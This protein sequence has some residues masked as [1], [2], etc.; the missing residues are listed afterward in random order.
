MI[1]LDNISS[2]G[3]GTYRMTLRNSTHSE[4]L[5]YAINKGVN[6]IDTSSNY[7]SGYS[8]QLI[9]E[10]LQSIDREDVFIITK[11]G[12]I[13]TDDLTNFKSILDND[14]TIKVEDDFYYSFH[15]S[16]L[17]KQ[18]EASLKRLNTSYIDGFLIH[19]P[20][21]YFEK[22]E[23][24]IDSIYQQL[25]ESLL[26]LEGLVHKGM[27][28]YYGISSNT[29]PTGGIDLKRLIDKSTLPHFRLVQFPYNLVENQAS[30][31]VNGTSLISFCKENGIITFA[32][33][34]LNTT[35]EGNVLRLANYNEELSKVDFSKEEGLFNQFLQAI[36][37][38]L[39]KF[40]ETSKPEDFTPIRFFI[41]N[42]K[43]IANPEAV[44]QAVQGHLLPFIQQLQ[45]SDNT[46][47]KLIQQLMMYWQFYAKRSITHRAEALK[48]DLIKEGRLNNNDHLDISTMACQS[49]LD[50]GIDH[51]LVGMRKKEYVDKLLASRLASI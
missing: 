40:G 17:E 26:F 5:Q 37:D 22:S 10:S 49:Y 43:K 11:A 46:I 3:L 6:L 44:A 2:L 30:Q 27:I 42:R 36:Q 39:T 23:E 25:Q 50:N 9:G 7:Q 34:P 33:R 24:S 28:R 51:V 20:E 13:Q 48:N 35:Y 29:L 21:Y 18:I 38:Q 16:F 12:Y 15:T 8:E 41:E 31:T 4:V 1:N 45:F 14:T 47:M 32:N 19:N